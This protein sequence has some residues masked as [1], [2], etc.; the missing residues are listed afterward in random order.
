MHVTDSCP[1]AERLRYRIA[2]AVIS[3]TGGSL[4]DAD[5][6]PS[7]LSAPAHDPFGALW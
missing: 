2:K 5:G 1:G 4:H 3:A 6:A 7:E